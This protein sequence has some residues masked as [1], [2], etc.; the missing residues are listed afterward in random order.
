[1]ADEDGVVRC[2]LQS[3]HRLVETP[4]PATVLLFSGRLRLLLWSTRF[5]PN[6]WSNIQGAGGLK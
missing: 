2:W 6:F 5:E 3:H 4:P 1:M